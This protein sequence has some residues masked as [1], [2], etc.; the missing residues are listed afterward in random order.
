[1]AV[2]VLGVIGLL[3]TPATVHAQ[4]D[5]YDYEYLSF[6]GIGADVGQIWPNKVEPT[7]SWGG[8]VDMGYAGPGL[9]IVPGLRFWWQRPAG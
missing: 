6:R 5:Q 1:M 4:L 2:L 8:R 9:R 3:T 7:T